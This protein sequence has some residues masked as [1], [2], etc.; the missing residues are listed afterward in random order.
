ME[1]DDEVVNNAARSASKDVPDKAFRQD[2]A[3]AQQP[4]A[5][6]VK[7]TSSNLEARLKT[8]R[9]IKFLAEFRQGDL[10]S[11][12]CSASHRFEQFIQDLKET[13]YF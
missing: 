5:Q 9:G 7:N 12:Q 8:S 4:A 1:S 6:D 10:G 3:Q 2:L 11:V 13:L